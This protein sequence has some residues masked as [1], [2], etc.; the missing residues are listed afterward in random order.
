MGPDGAAGSITEIQTSRKL[1]HPDG[2]RAVGPDQF[3]LIEG[4]G[5]LDRVK[6]EGGPGQDR[7]FER[8]LHRTYRGNARGWLG[9]GCGRQAFLL[10]ISEEEG[11]RSWTV[12]GVS[13]PVA[14]RAIT[15]RARLGW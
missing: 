3:L 1:E 6:I 14:E 4:A 10:G 12:Q 8:R 5:R 2:M 13:R 15:S 7:S 11:S 9:L